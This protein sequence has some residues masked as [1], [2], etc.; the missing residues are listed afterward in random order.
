MKPDCE[1]CEYHSE[2]KPGK[3][4][5]VPTKPCLTQKHLSLA[6]TPGV[7]EPCR[8]IETNPDD[9]FAYTAKSNLV[10]VVSNGSA[11]LGLG[12]I[13]PLACKPVMEGKGV[14][15]KRFANVDVFDIEINTSDPDEFIRTVELIS[16]T[17]GGINIEDVKAP[18]CFYI[19]NEL[20]KCLD[21]PVFHDDQHGTAIITA[22]GLLNALDI[23]GKNIRDVRIVMNGAGAAGIACAR[24]VVAA[25]AEKENIV[26]CDSRGVI[27]RKRTKGLNPQ[28]Q[29]F[30]SDT[31]AETLAE[32]LVGADVFIGISVRD[33]LTPDMLGA[34]AANPVVF[35]MANPDPEIR[36]DLARQ[37]RPDAIL[38]TGRSDY[39]N[40]VN[41]VLGF[42]FI[43]RGA[44]DARA[45]TI[46]R[47]MM[48]AAVH[49]LK[50]LARQAVPEDI[51]AAYGGERFEFGPGYIIPK[52]FDSRV[53]TSVSPAVA[54]AAMD[55]GVAGITFDVESYIKRL[56][57]Q[58]SD[59][60]RFACDSNS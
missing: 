5:V 16:P 11:T 41:N 17:F 42:P 3:I 43:F 56:E 25:G 6:Y 4:E 26:L 31:D 13:G 8:R 60:Q 34:M 20:K 58:L 28:K 14:L 27:N 47:E 33:C 52:P 10:A 24:L 7:A 54:R 1:A 9:A 48:L 55:S 57:D 46:N 2:G 29:E 53:L 19:E 45:S 23:A 21:I 40:Q 51:S 37:T 44:L 50:D 30:I 22:A 38:A 18:E 59:I 15:F 32:A 36:Y 39:P 49:A 12:D 35:A